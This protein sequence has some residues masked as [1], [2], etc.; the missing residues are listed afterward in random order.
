MQNHL[1]ITAL[2]D[3]DPRI[4]EHFTRAVKDCG[5]TISESRMVALGD[6]F[7][8]IMMLAGTWDAVAKME[9]LL[10]RLEERLHLSITSSRSQPQ[11]PNQSLMPYA[12]D[13]VSFD[14]IGVVH[15]ITKF[16]ANNN[17]D[18]QA[19]YTNSYKAAHTDTP[20]I[21]LHMTINIPTNVSIAALRGDFMDFCD[22]LN[23]DAIMEP[24]K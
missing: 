10:P 19:L 15:D 12:I 6:C 20:M 22:Q 7:A 18:I 8:M 5:C 17:I 11:R 1:V 13:V 16:I 14:Q 21:S 3:H 23:L 4:I 24:V 2:G 9:D